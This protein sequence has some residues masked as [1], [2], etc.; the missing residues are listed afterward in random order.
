MSSRK[1]GSQEDGD[2][3]NQATMNRIRDILDIVEQKTHDMLAK[4]VIISTTESNKPSAPQQQVKDA[5][6]GANRQLNRRG[7]LAAAARDH[8][9]ISACC[10]MRP[11]RRR[12]HVCGCEA[13]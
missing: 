9:S 13:I 12:Q 7:R 5:M 2:G 10:E 4:Y 3:V 11:M 1:D 8:C 6:P